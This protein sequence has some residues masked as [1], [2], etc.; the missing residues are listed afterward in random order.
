MTNKIMLTKEQYE[1]IDSLTSDL[2][3]II[4][5]TQE[6]VHPDITNT[7]ISMQSKLNQALHDIREIE[8]NSFEK[9]WKELADIAKNNN[10][11]SRWSVEEVSSEKM[12]KQV[13]LKIKTIQYQGNTF[14]VKAKLTWLE[15]W[16]IADQIIKNSGDEH[17]IFIENFEPINP[18]TG[19]FKLNTGS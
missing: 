16:K 18:T 5:R 4:Y 8:N 14:K 10:F 6:L 2:H 11:Q 7:L 15:L 9:N 19:A 3:S 13:P 17:H 1:K 12:S